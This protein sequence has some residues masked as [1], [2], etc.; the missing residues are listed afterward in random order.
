[1][2]DASLLINNTVLSFKLILCTVVRAQMRV[3]ALYF[4]SALLNAR[5]SSSFCKT[6]HVSFNLLD[7]CMGVH[8]WC[9]DLKISSPRVRVRKLDPRAVDRV[10]KQQ[11]LK[12]IE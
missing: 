5:C 9:G 12:S 8:Q 10:Q 1:M 4:V 3:S 2:S 6:F 11:Q 7:T